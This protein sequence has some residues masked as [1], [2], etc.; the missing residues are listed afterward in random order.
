[1]FAYLKGILVAANHLQAIVEVQGVG[2]QILISCRGYTQL[3]ALGEA[4]QL[5]TSFIVRE[6]SQTLYGFTSIQER[7]IFEILI[8]VTG[9]GPKMGLSLVGHLSLSELHSAVK[10]H[11]LPALC[12]V[13]G[14]G[15]K[16][17]ER[18][19]VELKD[20]LSNMNLLDAGEPAWGIGA[21][22]PKTQSVQD[23]MLALIN[24]GYNQNTAQKAI[25]QGL[26]ELPE[27]IDT[28][29]LITTALR[30]V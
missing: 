28:A 10:R 11:D 22:D 14:V 23:A 19:I 13:P 2:Y 15:K 20:K 16:T 4:V 5:H 9:I 7:E 6:L 17:A 21:G 25:K 12:R 18:L 1:M 26:K 27:E 24:L 30:H 8:N 3:P 29:C